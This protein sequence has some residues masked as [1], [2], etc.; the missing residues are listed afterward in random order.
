MIGYASRTGTLENRRLLREAGWRFLISAVE[1]LNAFGFPYCLDNGAWAAHTKGLPFNEHKFNHALN[2][3][4]SDA[5]FVVVPDIVEGGM[6]SLDFSLS[7]LERCQAISDLVLIPVQDGMDP[8]EVEPLLDEKVGIFVGGSTEF[9]V[10]TLGDWGKMSKRTGCWLHVG[11]VN[12]RKRIRLCHL[13][14][15]DSFDGSLISR[16]TKRYLPRLEG[17]LNQPTLPWGEM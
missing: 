6:K 2:A 3:I 15:A 9:K 13:A 14:G 1:K 10:N 5:D 17:G 7:W 16:Y 4:G 11:R 8:V 12:S